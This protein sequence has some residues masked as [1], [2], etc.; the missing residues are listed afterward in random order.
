[1]HPVA[2]VIFKALKNERARIID[3][4]TWTGLEASNISRWKRGKGITLD[5][6]FR[7]LAELGITIEFRDP[8]GR[9]LEVLEPSSYNPAY[10]RQDRPL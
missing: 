9:V 8:N 6:A 7:C 5:S 10:Q 4:A 2:R 1:M 3:L